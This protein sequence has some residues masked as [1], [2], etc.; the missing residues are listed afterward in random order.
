MKKILLLFAFLWVQTFVHAQF[1][2]GANAIVQFPQGDFKFSSLVSY[3]GSASVGYTFDQRVDLSFVYTAYFYD[4][5][6]FDIN[7]KM[8]EAKFFFFNGNARPYI[9]CGVGIFSKTIPFRYAPQEREN[10]WG[11]EPKVGIL[12]D[13]K[14]LRNLFIDASVTYFKANTKFNDPQAFNVAVGLKYMMDWEKIH[15]MK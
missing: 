13:S 5:H 12:L 2:V 3:G 9:G 8:V 10:V 15:S 4:M 11:Y 7:S 6:N 14:M 1:N